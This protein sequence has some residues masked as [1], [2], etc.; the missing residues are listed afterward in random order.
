[1]DLRKS[2]NSD[3]RSGN[4]ELHKSTNSEPRGP[5]GYNINIKF[6]NYTDLE[7]TIK[8]EKNKDIL[9][10]WSDFILRVEPLEERNPVPLN[11]ILKRDKKV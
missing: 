10:D 11:Q 1:M 2:T 5:R 6:M 3:F 9:A 7:K 4:S 8:C